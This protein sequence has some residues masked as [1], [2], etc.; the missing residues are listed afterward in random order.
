MVKKKTCTLLQ[1]FHFYS[2]N[3]THNTSDNVSIWVLPKHV[4]YRQRVYNLSPG[5][6]WLFP[7]H[8]P[9]FVALF[10]E[11]TLKI[12]PLLPNILS[13]SILHYRPVLLCFQDK[14]HGGR[15]KMWHPELKP[16]ENECFTSE[17]KI[18]CTTY[19]NT[20]LKMVHMIRILC[21]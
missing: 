12:D 7:H 3:W 10:L 17:C 19:R 6:L 14:E 16:T 18:K 5:T 2:A 21:L 8:L 1:I 13:S 11:F 20:Y 4:L 9:Q 15:V